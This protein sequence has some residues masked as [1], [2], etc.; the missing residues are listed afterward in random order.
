MAHNSKIRK[1]IIP[2]AGLGTRFF[3]ATKTV[4][5]EMLPI[6]D[7]PAILYVIEEAVQAGI[8]DIVLIQGRGKTAI[9]DF[10]DVSYELEDKLIK[11]GKEEI[12]KQ[13]Q[14][15]RNNTNIISIRQKAALGLGHAVKCAESI[16]GDEAFAVLLGD[17]I[18]ISKEQK[19]NVTHHLIKN[20]EEKQNSGVWVLPVEPQETHKYGIVDLS[21]QF[22]N[23]THADLLNGLK[24]KGVIE[25]PKPELAP[26]RWALPGRYIFQAEIM[27]YLN[28]IQ[29]GYNGEWQLSDAMNLMAQKS[30]LMAYSFESRRFDTGDKLGFLQANIELALERPDLREGL[31][32]YIKGK[33]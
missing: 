1:A 15:I 6:V 29:P 11:D 24:V 18:T 26:S 17:E 23:S 32:K 27:R 12:L 31:L 2:A 10:F 20:C 22:K 8:T 9:E 21:P 5:K 33:I 16:I 19:N 3:P 14:F 30:D 13:I 28:E 7:R 25:K 4:P